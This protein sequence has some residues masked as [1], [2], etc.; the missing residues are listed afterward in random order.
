MRR[1]MKAAGRAASIL[2]FLILSG[3][4]AL[5]AQEKSLYS[6]S[7]SLD[8][9][10]Y[11]LKASIS[12]DV[13]SAGLR[14]PSGRSQAESM[15]RDEAP[16]LLRDKLLSLQIDS[17]RDLAEAI[18]SGDVSLE[19]MTDLLEASQAGKSAF[20]ADFRSFT[21]EYSVSLL[22][23]L[24]LLVRHSRAG[25][26]SAVLDYRPTKGYSGIVIYASGPLPVHGEFKSDAFKPSFFPRVW[27]EKMNLVFE[28]NMVDPTAAKGGGIVAYREKGDTGIMED[29]VGGEPLRVMA[30][31]IF[32]IDHC[33]L[34]ISRE[35]ALL[36][37]TNS[38]NRGL[39]AA[40][41]VIIVIDKASGEF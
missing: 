26:Q 32:G 14:L 41:K 7:G 19:S 2:A 17:R 28:R 12:L 13:A 1:T 10:S 11:S 36:I 18:A 33:D 37:Q 6:V 30:V 9:S 20:S 22:G 15:I 23:I 34:L 31:G 4:A 24:A 3:G 40:G 8:W 25:A 27:D 35:D 16:R 5:R 29:R 21:C 39:L 38:Q